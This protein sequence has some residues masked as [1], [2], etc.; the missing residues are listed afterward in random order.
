MYTDAT[1]INKENFRALLYLATKYDVQNLVDA[2]ESYC[3][4]II[5]LDEVCIWMN[6]ATNFNLNGLWKACIQFIVINNMHIFP[7]NY[8]DEMSVGTLQRFAACDELA[9]E[10]ISIFKC[11]RSWAEEEC[12]KLEIEYNIENERKVLGDS[13]QRIRFPT[14]KN[15]IFT[16]EIATTNV[17]T[18]E[19]EVDVHRS[20]NSDNKIPSKHFPQ[21]PRLNIKETFGWHGIYINKDQQ[22][23]NAYK[24]NRMTLKSLILHVNRSEIFYISIWRAKNSQFGSSDIYDIYE[25]EVP[26]E[27]INRYFHVF[28]PQPGYDLERVTLLEV[29][30]YYNYEKTCAKRNGK[31]EISHVFKDIKDD[32]QLKAVFNLKYHDI[33]K[34]PHGNG[35]IKACFL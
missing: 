8:L 26:R 23:L 17:L 4:S 28:L 6:L 3:I 9:I 31:I 5:T 16:N 11:L 12:S 21:C 34:A 30:T 14:I 18:A 10:E 7:S 27:C 29:N 19:E 22:I 20:L 2:C 24:R 15:A 13:L 1:D 25:I 35:H 32:D 33:I